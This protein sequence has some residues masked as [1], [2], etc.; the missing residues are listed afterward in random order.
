MHYQKII[1]RDI[2]PT[3]LLLGEDGHVKI[4]DFGIS[5][6][7]EGSDAH[8]SSMAGTPAFMAPEMM[9]ELEQ[10]AGFSGKVRA[11]PRPWLWW[12]WGL[13]VEKFVMRRW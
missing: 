11:D 2:K 1:H 6:V 3:N 8:L 9:A 10:G 13:V 7:F 12:W 5:N 4:A